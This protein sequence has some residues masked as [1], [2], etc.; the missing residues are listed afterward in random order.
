MRTKKWHTLKINHSHC[1]TACVKKSFMTFFQRTKI[2]SQ[3]IVIFLLSSSCNC[4]GHRVKIENTWILKQ[5][6]LLCFLFVHNRHVSDL[7]LSLYL[8]TECKTSS[9]RKK[10]NRGC[11]NKLIP[12]IFQSRMTQNSIESTI[13]VPLNYGMWLHIVRLLTFLCFWLI[14]GRCFNWNFYSLVIQSSKF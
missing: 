5:T 2:K 7:T 12:R 9:F 11:R 8:S 14:K 13:T 6:F 4:Q 1:K 3:I 10:K